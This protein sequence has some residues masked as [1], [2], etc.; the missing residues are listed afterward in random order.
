CA[1]NCVVSYR[2]VFASSN[3]GY[4]FREL[5]ALHFNVAPYDDFWTPNQFR[6]KKCLL[7]DILEWFGMLIV[8]PKIRSLINSITSTPL[9]NI[10]ESLKSFVW[11]FDKGDFHHWVDLFNHFDSYFEKHIK[12]RQDLQLE[13]D[14]LDRDPPFPKE[15]VLQILRVMRIILENCLNKHFLVSYEQHLSCLLASADADVVEASLQT[16]ATF[17]KKTMGKYSIRDASLSSRL[18]SFAQGW[19]CKEEGLGLIAC[20]LEN[21]RDSIAEQLGSTLLYEF[22][23]V[24][25]CLSGTEATPGLQIIHVPKIDSRPESDLEILNMLVKEYQVPSNFRFSLFTRLRFARAFGSLASRQRYTCIRLYAFMVVVQASS[26]TD[27]LVSFF[28]SEPEF[29]NELV[30]LLSFED[31]VP[32][33]IRI[34]SLRALVALCQDRSRQPTVLTAVTSG[35]QRGILS[36]LMQKAVDSAINGSSNWSVVFAEALLSLVTVLVSSSSGCSAM[37][38]SGFIPTLLPLL[39]DTNPQHLHLV[40]TAVHVL[41]AFMDYS[42]PAAALFRDLGG[43]DDT[44]HRLKM[45]VSVVESGFDGSKMGNNYVTVGTSAVLDDVHP[46]YSES[47]LA[48]HRRLLMKALLRAISLG[49]YA[50]GSTHRIYDSEESLLPQCLCIVFRRAKDF[51]GGLFSLAA[52]VTSELIHNDPTCFPALDAAGLPSAFMDAIM[53]GVLCSAD[54]ITCIPPCLDAFCLNNN[55]LQAVKD[56]NALNCF[57]K[58]FTSKAYLRAL[59]GEAPA[60]LSSGLDELMRHAAALRGPGVDMLVEILN[61]IVKLGSVAEAPS[62]MDSSTFSAPVLMETDLETNSFPSLIDEKELPKSESPDSGDLSGDA[63]LANVE[64]YLPDCLSNVARLLETILQNTDACRLFIEKKGIETVLKMF[65]LPLLPISVPVGQSVSIAFKNFS[66]QHSASLARAVCSFLREHLNTT[67]EALETTGGV[68]L[69]ELEATEQTKVLRCLSSLEGILSLSNSLLKGTTTVI[70][71]LGAGDADVLKGI[72]RVYREVLWQISLSCDSKQNVEVEAENVEAAPS[73]STGRES[74]DDTSIPVVRYMNPVSIR[75]GSQ[76][77]W[78]GERDFLSVFRSGEGLS[79]RNRHGLTRIRGGRAGRHL[80][81]FSFDSEASASALEAPPSLEQKK[82]SPEI[83]ASEI[84]SKLSGTMRSFYTALIKGF[85]SPSRRRA[86]SWSTGSVAKNIGTALAKNF[87]DALSFCGHSTSAGLDISLSVKCRYLGKVV[88]DMAALTFDSRRRVC[89]TAMVNNFYVSG[90]FKELLTTYE[91]TSQLLWSLPHS[92]PMTSTDIDKAGE[93]N[94]LEHSSWLLDTLQNYCRLLE[95]FVNSSLLLSPNSPS[96]AQLLVQPVAVGLS[97]GLFP[98]PRDPQV[99][100]RMLQSQVLDVILPVWNHPMFPHCSVTFITS[101]LLVVTHIYSG[102]GDV[103]HNRNVVPGNLNPRVAPPPDED[104]VA[105]I[106]DMGFSRVRAEEALRQVESNSVEMAMDWLCTHP[107]DPVQEDGELAQALAL[108]L[109]SSTEASKNDN[110]DKSADVVGEDGQMKVPPVDDILGAAMKLFQSGD[111][112]AFPLTDLLTTLCNR[113]KGEDRQK[114]A[115]YLIQSLRLCSTDLSKNASAV[116]SISHILALLLSEDTAT[117]EIASQNGIVS[118]AI[119]VLRI[120]KMENQ[121]GKDLLTTKSTSALLLVLDNLLQSRPR[122]NPEDLRVASTRPLPDSSEEIVSVAAPVPDAKTPGYCE[123]SHFAFQKIFGKLTGYLSM[124]ESHAVLEIACDM[125]HLHVPAVIMQAVLQIC[126]RLTKTHAL[127]LK[128][129]E[130]GGLHALFN[131]PRGCFFPGYDTVASAIVR[132]LLEDPQTLQ[133]A[134]EHEIRQTLSGGRHA[135]RIPTRMFL[136]SMAPVIS[137]DPVTFTKA[138]AAVCQLETSAGRTVVVLTKEKE[139]EKEKA[140]ST[141]TE[142]GL[143]SNESVKVSEPKVQDGPGKGSRGHKKIPANL[144]QVIDQLLEIVLQFPCSSSEEDHI[145]NVTAMELD[146]ATTKGK[147][148]LKVDESG[149]EKSDH[150]P[151]ISAALAKVTFILKLLSEILLMYV[152]AVSVVLRR[153]SDVC[154][155]RVTSHP[156]TSSQGG[157]F[158]HVLHKLLPLSTDQSGGSIELREKLSEKASWFLVVLCGRSSEGRRRVISE[159]VKALSLYSDLRST[160]ESSLLPSRKVLALVELVYSV[161][162]KN[163]SSSS[164]SVSGYSPDVARSMIDGGIVLCL[165][166]ILES[167]DLDHP[168][169][170]KIANLILKSLESLTRAANSSDPAIKSDSLNKQS[171]TG[172]EVQSTDRTDMA[173]ENQNTELRE[174]RFSDQDVRDRGVAEPSSREGNTDTD[175]TG[176]AEQGTLAINVGTELAMGFTRDDMEEGELM[177]SSDQISMEFHVENRADDDIGDGDDDMGGDGEEDDEDDEEDE[178]EDDDIP[179]DG[180]A[181][182]S[183]ADTDG[184]DHE[185]TRLGDDYNNEIVDEE[186][187]DYNDNRVIEVRWG[188][189]LDGFHQLQVAQS[190][191]GLIDVPS[192]PFQGVNVDDLFGFTSTLG[193]ERRRQTSRSFD[194]S[195]AEGGFQ[196]PLLLRPTQLGDVSLWSSGGNASRE[197]ESL[198]HF[199]MFDTPPITYDLGSASLF[200]DRSGG[201]GP[202]PLTDYSVGMD[203]MQLQ[204][205]G[206]RGPGDGRWADDGQP[207]VGNQASAIAQ[208]VEDTFVT[209]LRGTPAERQSENTSNQQQLDAADAQENTN[210]L[211]GNTLDEQTNLEAGVV[212]AEENVG[213]IPMVEAASD[214][215]QGHEPTLSNSDGIRPCGDIMTLE[216]DPLP[217]SSDRE[218]NQGDFVCLDNSNDAS[219]C[220]VGDG[221]PSNNVVVYPDLEIPDQVDLDH[222]ALPVQPDVEMIG[223]DGEPIQTNQRM[224]SPIHDENGSLNP[225]SV[226]SD[227]IGEAVVEQPGSSAIDPTFLEALPEDLRAEVLA[228]QQSQSAQPPTYSPPSMEDIDPE[229]LA[230]LPPDIQAEVLAQQRAQRLAQQSEGQP[231]DMDNASII[232]TLPSDLREEVLLT[233]SEAVL[234]ALPSPLLAEAQMLRDRAMSHYQAR[235]L[236]GGSHRLSHHRR[237]G[238]DR[239]SVMDRGVGVTM[240]R[241]TSSSISDIMK[242]KEFEGE[243]LLDGNALR[244]LLRLLRLA[245]PLGKGLLQRLLLNLC[246][247]SLTRATLVHLL[248]GMITSET[249]GTVTSSSMINSQRLYGCPSNVVYGLPPLVLRRVLEILSYLAT[250]HSAVADTLFYFERS[251]LPPFTEKLVETKKG[252]GKEKVEEIGATLNFI[253]GS[254]EGSIPLVLLLKLLNRPLFRRSIAHIEQV[255]GLLQVVVYTAASRLESLSPPKQASSEP[256][257]H[258]TEES[259]EQVQRDGNVVETETK[260]PSEVE[261]GE[262]STSEIKSHNIYDIFVQL[263][264]ADLRNVS[265]LLGCEGLSDK[266]YM[267]AGEVLKK[268]ALVAI[269]HRKFFTLE[270]SELAQELSSAAVAELSTLKN[271]RM[272]GLSSGSMAGASM[273][274]VLQVLSSLISSTADSD[275]QESNEVQAEQAMLLKLSSDLEPLWQELS[276]CIGTTESEL[277]QSSLSPIMSVGETVTG[278]SPSSPPLP[279]GTQRLLPF[280]ESFFVLC[281]KLQSSNSIVQ[282]DQAYVTGREVKESAESSSSSLIKSSG[283]SQKKSDTTV[284]FSWFADKHRRLLNAF[285]RQSPGLLEKSLSMMLKSPRLIDFDNKRSYFRSRIRQQHEQHLAGPLRVSVRRAYVLEDSYNQLRMRSTQ[286]LKGRLNVQFQGEEGI[287]AGGLTRE[288]YQL[289][290]RV[291]FDK[292][293]LLF[294]TVG[295]NATFQPNPNSVY[296]TEHLS[297][298]KF[299]GRVVAKAL[300]DGQL[301]DVYFTRSFYKHILGVKVTYHDIEAV[302]P[303]YY[304]NLKWMLENDVNDILDL[305]FSMDADEEKLILYEK[306]QCP[307]TLSCVTGVLMQKCTLYLSLTLFILLVKKVTDYELKPGGRNIRVTEETKQEYVDLVADHILTNAIRPQINS[308]LEGFTELVPR[309]LISIFNDKELE[310]LISGLP[311]IDLEDL[312]ANAEYTGYTAGSSVIQWF[313]DVASGF[314]KEDMARLLQFVTGTSKVPLEGFKALQG[315]SGPQRFQIHKAYG[316]PERLPSAHTCFNQL[317]L[318]EYSS[319]EQLRERL[320]LAIHEASEGFGF[321]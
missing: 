96:Q 152:Q 308:F 59:A 51:G 236:F 196:H 128:F 300:F 47:L 298:F 173:I 263:P 170:P 314:S 71:E 318:P 21:G 161:L 246:A 4:R 29:T 107:E 221:L 179:E 181:I 233:S 253:E 307:V 70:S 171:G 239:Q 23:R 186:E 154:Q 309:E 64:S 214:F 105:T 284:I 215:A 203:S 301:L 36:S 288:W 290:S 129:L 228:S 285:I 294:T 8:P 249:E 201:S 27:N 114:V 28:N 140:K 84:L 216:P 142:T 148:K 103:K 230:A 267:L 265:R 293:A 108:S 9:E 38:D 62:S 90:A 101:V 202:P 166:G 88:H 217:S 58:V 273:L 270:L 16:L 208:A 277:G 115:S 104:T 150:V 199:Y 204:L 12:P 291:I 189:A 310:L 134:M 6:P 281:E 94:K 247:H 272:M 305:T 169:A 40:A 211:V 306:T 212:S 35:G 315:I 183:L 157:V 120:Y 44:I 136:T 304:K 39:K 55:G 213:V 48:Y 176:S 244:A 143:S 20:A 320:L 118:I 97:I 14:F 69:T 54:A 65:S 289:L 91:A 193:L 112:M 41:E 113:N 266:V 313:W 109:G 255:M 195:N 156:D 131:L 87:V 151:E 77:H 190:G 75:G 297:Y 95:Y 316:A 296:Q 200:G 50:P 225:D 17:L 287:D 1:E 243:P 252:K 33:K 86:D 241:K 92:I 271:T 185:D 275:V 229:F 222:P 248:L 19:G 168:D 76:S 89:Y 218:T 56:R 106:V 125:L 254:E 311:E 242:L 184:D 155:L 250:N 159:L 197:S 276:D 205:S 98:V 132:H 234:S 146:E 319:K 226:D 187:D 66:A 130:I 121:L 85:N 74:D 22:Y 282:Q 32:E 295:S 93:G 42:N 245:Q 147:G 116:S 145:S 261:N 240:G 2:V 122:V 144:T 165:T 278:P 83:L 60:S 5:F 303:D 268:L 257:N 67:I 279:P 135:G 10:Q 251:L 46:F 260:Q 312:K 123:E 178:D 78:A 119:D 102:V 180:T 283:D 160:P 321:G 61:T 164:I 210:N 53:D 227:N 262:S 191:S 3:L 43:L 81:T 238:F 256:Q 269:S 237:L 7:Q 264:K 82:K 126:A 15:A 117:R 18:F 163:S 73:A 99:F 172:L 194:R 317:D 219:V 137:R 259:D 162:S 223:T 139:K 34:L 141:A 127:A 111:S 174:N 37:R 63:S 192:E 49:T 280:I 258:S 206:R 25:E 175:L 110:N 124:D 177:P 11:D 45:E 57:V 231:V 198:S 26:D 220:P 235:S 302:D 188:E 68:C 31:S 158:H 167:I 24:P 133:T 286:D 209:L 72:G 274:R 138:A 299:V 30:S 182:M 232:A 52:N 207:Q 224:A 13:D 153:D 100:V 292:G 149:K 79:R 80:D